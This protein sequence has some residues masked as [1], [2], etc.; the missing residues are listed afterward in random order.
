ML[1]LKTCN[2]VVKTNVWSEETVLQRTGA[3]IVQI[4]MHH[5]APWLS[6][7]EILQYSQLGVTL[8]LVGR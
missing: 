6:E 1:K 2:G 8:Y 3:E 4:I 7:T 5:K